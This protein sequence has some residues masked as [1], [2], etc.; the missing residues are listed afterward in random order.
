MIMPATL[1]TPVSN[2]LID[3]LP[4]AQRTAFRKRCELV[5]M[6]FGSSLSAR[7][8]PIEHVYFPLTGFISQVITVSGHPP[9]ELGLIGNEGMLGAT[10]AL[11]ADTAP[12][13][14][15]VQGSGTALRM[16]TAQFRSELTNSAALRQTL[17]RYLYVSLA[18]LAQTAACTRFHDIESRLA[19]W[20]LM[21][22]DRAHADHLHLTHRFLADMLGVRRSGVTIAARSL[23]HKLLIRYSRGEIT[24]LDRPGLEAAACECYRAD[25]ADY[26]RLLAG[27][28]RTVRAAL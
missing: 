1:A 17:S 14:A 23:H 26:E 13:H 20:M 2:R 12:L 6:V 24:V 18:Q 7:K 5:N 25:I 19:R 8:D 27:P 16:S 28:V 3:G 9:M 4:R 11:G 22:H 15:V 10:L 21:T